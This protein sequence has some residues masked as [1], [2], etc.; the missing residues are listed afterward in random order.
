EIVRRAQFQPRVAVV[1]EILQSNAFEYRRTPVDSIASYLLVIT[2]KTFVIEA[3]TRR[4]PSEQ[5]DIGN[6][7]AERRDRWIVDTNVQMTPG[8]HDIELLELSGCGKENIGEV[9]RV[10]HELFADHCEQIF[11]REAGD[12]ALLIGDRHHRIA[13]IN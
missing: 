12:H 4:Q 7:F 9:G 1:L 8:P 10:T 5:L 3:H 11:A 13:V 2:P 6:R